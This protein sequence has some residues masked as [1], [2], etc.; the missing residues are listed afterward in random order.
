MS[1]HTRARVARPTRSRATV[2]RY[3]A[4]EYARVAERAR[5]SG[6]PVA[7]YIREASLGAP[8]RARR[9]ADTDPAIRHLGRVAMRLTE[10]ARLATDRGLPDAAQ[11]SA[12]VTET[13]D[14]IRTLD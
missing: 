3:T 12:A 10:L 2:V 5:E 11:F 8:P 6:R 9:T 1:R 14:A 7:R 4:D 13:L